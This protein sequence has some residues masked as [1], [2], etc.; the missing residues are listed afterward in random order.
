[1]NQAP[2][3][4]SIFFLFRSLFFIF[5]FVFRN[6]LIE[7]LMNQAPTISHFFFLCPTLFTSCGLFDVGL[8][9]QILTIPFFYSTGGLDES[10]PYRNKNVCLI[11]KTPTDKSSPYKLF[12]SLRR[13]LAAFLPIIFASSS[14]A[15]FF[16][17]F[18]SLYLASRAAF[19]LLP[20]PGI[21]SSLDSK[22]LFSLLRR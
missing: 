12:N 17:S 21:L 18:I 13:V 10:S 8:M 5:C 9:N 1:M 22:L 14:G 3:T 2:T 19:L 20:K 15:A 4:R 16:I 6:L 11:N 7:G